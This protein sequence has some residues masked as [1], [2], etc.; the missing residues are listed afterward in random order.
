MRAAWN[1]ESQTGIQAFTQENLDGDPINLLRD[2]PGIWLSS[3]V[4][5]LFATLLFWILFPKIDTSQR[6]DPVQESS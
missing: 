4:I 1:I 3:A 2:W 5:A 6:M